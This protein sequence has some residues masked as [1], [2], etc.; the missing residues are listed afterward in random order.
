MLL[1]ISGE[2]IVLV[3]LHL[4]LEQLQMKDAM[5]QF[6]IKDQD[7]LGMRNEFIGETFISFTDIPKTEM[8]VGLEQMEQ[9][10]L[11][12][13][14]PASLAVTDI[15]FGEFKGPM[16]T[17]ELDSSLP[18]KYYKARQVPFVLRARLDK[19]NQE[20]V[21]LQLANAP[22]VLSQTTEDGEIEVRIS[23]ARAYRPKT[24]KRAGAYRPRSF[25]RAR[26]YHPRVFKRARAFCLSAIKRVRA[27]CLRAIKRARAY[28]LRAFKKARAYR[29]R[30]VKRARK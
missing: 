2:G 10:H 21:Y 14:R 4:T 22:V 3:G 9:I 12:L 11:K 23:R 24:I 5:V 1:E 26:A 30:A 13:S 20:P 16:E 29:P 18:S 17:L 28:H 6:V 15:T 27:Y 8:T 7:F 19:E 25:E